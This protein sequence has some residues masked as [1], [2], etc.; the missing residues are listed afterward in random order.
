[1]RFSVKPGLMGWAQLKLR[2]ESSRTCELTEFEYDLYYVKRG[3]PLLDLDILV[4]TLLGSS[5]PKV[6]PEIVSAAQ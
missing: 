1:M 5:R 4:G 2:G 6:S 3:S